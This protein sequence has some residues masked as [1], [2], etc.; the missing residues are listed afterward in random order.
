VPRDALMESLWPGQHPA[1][2]G[3]RLS[4]LSTCARARPREAR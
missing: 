2:L 4:V 3:N 1:P